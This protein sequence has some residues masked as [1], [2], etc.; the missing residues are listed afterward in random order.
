MQRDNETTA[1]ELVSVVNRSGVSLSKTTVLKGRRL[2]GWTRRGTVYCQLSG[3]NH[4]KRLEWAMQNLGKMFD[5]VIWSDE[6]SVQLETHRRFQ[7]Y[8]RGQKPHCKLRPKHPTK[9]HV[10][11]GISCRGPTGVCIF[12]GIMDATMYTRILDQ[13]LVPFIRDVYPSGHRFMQ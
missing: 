5:D 4:T 9:V 12:D 8:K 6:T 2:L 11:V 1:K 3:P 7:C 10:W 13:C